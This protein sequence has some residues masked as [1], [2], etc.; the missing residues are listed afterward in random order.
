MCQFTTLLLGSCLL[1][2]LLFENTNKARKRTFFLQFQL[3][4]LLLIHMCRACVHA[5]DCASQHF[6]RHS[7]HKHNVN[8]DSLVLVEW[9]CFCFKGVF[10][11]HIHCKRNRTIYNTISN[12]CTLSETSEN[13]T[14][15]KER[16]EIKT[17]KYTY[18]SE[19]LR[20]SNH[21]AYKQ[22]HRQ[23]AATENN[24]HHPI[25][26]FEDQ[27]KKRTRKIPTT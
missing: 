4:L 20:F 1:C 27:K 9:W 13:E 26:V 2:S 14:I 22:Q 16:N 15:T 6:K 3:S 17:I 21:N 5:F 25:T 11:M 10:V 19:L 23:L 24:T 12:V 8:L 18:R 7:A